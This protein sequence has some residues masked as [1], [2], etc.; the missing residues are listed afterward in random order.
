[1]TSSKNKLLNL[2]ELNE[3]SSQIL[4]QCAKYNITSTNTT[5]VDLRLLEETQTGLK[6]ETYL[7]EVDA[8]LE[9]VS[10]EIKAE[11]EEVESL[12]KVLAEHEPVQ[13]DP[14][15]IKMIEK[16]GG[17]GKEVQT[18]DDVNLMEIINKVKKLEK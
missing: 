1:M 2:F 16:F 18:P 12:K 5:S 11:L 6:L 10:N 3:E 7:I 13:P 9:T 14:K 15:I 4:E 8:E 17:V